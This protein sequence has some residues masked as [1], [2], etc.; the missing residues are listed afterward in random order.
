MSLSLT[1][2]SSPQNVVYLAVSPTHRPSAFRCFS[3]QSHASVVGDAALDDVAWID[4][5]EREPRRTVLEAE[6]R[7]QSTRAAVEELHPVLAQLL[8]RARQ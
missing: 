7:D 1:S 8:E 5:L 6:Q 2:G 4:E 3:K